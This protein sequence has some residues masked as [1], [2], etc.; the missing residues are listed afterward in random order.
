MTDR[1]LAKRAAAARRAFGVA[2]MLSGA[3]ALGAC[4][5]IQ[6]NGK[7]FDAVGL[8]GAGGP[9]DE[10]RLAERAP[11]VPPPRNDVL[12]VP[13]SIAAPPEGHMAW[14][15]DPDK[16]RAAMAAAA[17]Q[18]QQAEC[19]EQA[20]RNQAI[21]PGD[22]HKEPVDCGNSLFKSLTSPFR[23]N[24]DGAAAET[25]DEGDSAPTKPQ[26]ATTAVQGGK[27]TGR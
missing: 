17:R 9:K 27:A 24:K 4:D 18:Q 26:Q 13:G 14:P 3:L 5:G 16:R 15:N 2:A 20:N 8:S 22:M 7:L 6:L 10:P 21:R 23:K 1:H 12:P 19:R 11:L 25:G